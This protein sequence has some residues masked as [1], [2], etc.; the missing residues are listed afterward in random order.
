MGVVFQFPESQLFEE[1]VL[2]DVAFGPQNFG[3]SQEEALKI[4]REKLELVGL[5]E[6]NFEK[7]PLN[8]QVDKCAVL[9]LRG[10]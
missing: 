3:V 2:K 10:F 1:T 5:A 9:P 7:S 4:A 6:K 8:Y